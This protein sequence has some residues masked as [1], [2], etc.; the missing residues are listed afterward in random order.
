[1]SASQFSAPNLHIRLGEARLRHVLD[2]L[3]DGVP[4]TAMPLLQCRNFKQEHEI[5]LWLYH[6]QIKGQKLVEFFKNE[7][8]SEDGTGYLNAINEILKRITRE[9]NRKANIKDLK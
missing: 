2:F 7:S 1:M 3:Y 8:K 6:N 5:Y 4:G 9:K